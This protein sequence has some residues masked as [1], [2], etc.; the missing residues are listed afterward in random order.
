MTGRTMGAQ[1]SCGKAI[2][3]CLTLLEVR[4]GTALPLSGS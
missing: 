4:F 1:A 2:F 3:R